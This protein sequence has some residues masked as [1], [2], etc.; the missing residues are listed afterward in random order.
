LTFN[1]S[2]NT[3]TSSTAVESRYNVGS[4]SSESKL[5]YLAYDRFSTDCLLRRYQNRSGRTRPESL[6]LENFVKSFDH[7]VVGIHASLK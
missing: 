6:E 5:T 4:Q 3:A 1:T 7:Q 2:I